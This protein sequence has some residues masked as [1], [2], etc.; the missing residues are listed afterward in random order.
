[1]LG[2]ADGTV[3]FSVEPDLGITT[4]IVDGNGNTFIN[5]Q[6]SAGTYCIL[7]RDADGCLAGE[8]CLRSYGT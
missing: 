8:A 7:A 6:L 4:E 3:S 1:M 5:G 2:A